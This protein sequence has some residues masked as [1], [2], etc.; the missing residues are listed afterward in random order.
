[1]PLWSLVDHGRGLSLLPEGP[2]CQV[3][4]HACRGRVSRMGLNSRPGRNTETD[5]DTHAH[6]CTREASGWLGLCAA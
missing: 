6:A 3:H 5:T 4:P 2:G 1:M